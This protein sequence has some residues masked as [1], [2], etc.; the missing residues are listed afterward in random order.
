MSD[1]ERICQQS[2]L[3]TVFYGGQDRR[4]RKGVLT[5]MWGSL[6]RTEAYVAF[7]CWKLYIKINVESHV[8]RVPLKLGIKYISCWLPQNTSAKG[9]NLTK[10]M[11][12]VVRR[13]SWYSVA[14]PSVQGPTRQAETKGEQLYSHQETGLG[15]ELAELFNFSRSLV[16]L[17]FFRLLTEP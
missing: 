16:P 6:G 10:L 9:Q 4:W 17:F 15:T 11:Y 13:Q 7:D 1:S 14:G 8:W 2:G 5:G 12:H 3:P